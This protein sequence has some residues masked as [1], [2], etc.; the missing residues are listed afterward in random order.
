MF[1]LNFCVENVLVRGRGEGGADL[2]Y[3]YRNLL[4]YSFFNPKRY[5]V[6]E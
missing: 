5:I 1:P 6:M 3:K 4:D 2:K